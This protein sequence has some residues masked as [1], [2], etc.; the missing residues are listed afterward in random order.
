MAV[1]CRA[2]AGLSAWTTRHND[3][4]IGSFPVS[5]IHLAALPAMKSYARII[6]WHRMK[7]A[8]YIYHTF[9]Y[10]WLTCTNLEAKHLSPEPSCIFDPSV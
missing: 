10:E 7:E 1:D 3:A 9:T 2:I 5:L 4:I 8:L 6:S